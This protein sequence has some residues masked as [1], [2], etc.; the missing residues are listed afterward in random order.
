MEIFAKCQLVRQAFCYFRIFPTVVILR[1]WFFPAVSTQTAQKP[2]VSREKIQTNG[3]PL[4]E[5]NEFRANNR[6]LWLVSFGR[7]DDEAQLKR[8]AKHNLA[9]LVVMSWLPMS[10]TPAQLI[11]EHELSAVLPWLCSPPVPHFVSLITLS[12]IRRRLSEFQTENRQIKRSV[13][14]NSCSR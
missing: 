2:A 11:S 5:Q 7:I 9:D 6:A 8:P 13:A 1:C 12:S 14:T 10:H 3:I 4:A